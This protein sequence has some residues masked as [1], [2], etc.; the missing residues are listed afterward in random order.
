MK[1]NEQYFETSLLR[2]E[3][4]S[5]LIESGTISLEDTMMLFEEANELFQTCAEKLD[6]AEKKLHILTGKQGSF[7]LHLE[8]NE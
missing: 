2:L 8:E 6:Q 7:Q 1:K 4:I 5:Q 3:E